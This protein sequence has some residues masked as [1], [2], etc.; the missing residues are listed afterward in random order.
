MRILVTGAE[1]FTGRHFMAAARAAAMEPVAL[2]A[3]LTQRD[4]LQQEVRAVQPTQVV[5]LA[6]VAH[7]A[8]SD[9]QAYY[10]INLFGTLNLLD[11]LS[12]LPT[13]PDC[14]LLASSANVYGNCASSPISESETPAPVNHYATS[15][16]AMECMARTHA[17]RLRLVISRPFNY[18]GPGQDPSFLVPKL[19]QH[20]ARRAPVIELGN[21][22][23]RREFNDIR[24]VCD[25][26]LGLLRQGGAGEIYNICSGRTW[27]LHELI[28]QLGALTG[29]RIEAQSRAHLARPN[30]IHTLC[31]SPDKLY[32]AVGP[33]R[34]PSL[35]DTL[36]TMLRAV[37]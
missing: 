16:L 9:A 33:I 5:H 26:Y 20:F 7:V 3:D 1:G 36:A 24:G 29:H 35:Q 17:Q 31:G 12:E 8:S 4:A 23:V 25:A 13:P 15:K 37:S 30:E 28:D 32:R 34:W 19:V 10:G 27:S 11:A 18:T 22:H 14:T 2:R 6:G 21:L